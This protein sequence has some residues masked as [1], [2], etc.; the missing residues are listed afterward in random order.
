ML[1]PKFLS[2]SVCIRFLDIFFWEYA[3]LRHN[4]IDTILNLLT[5]YF[6]FSPKCWPSKFCP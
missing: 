3:T 5:Y 1:F 2:G 6:F 4:I